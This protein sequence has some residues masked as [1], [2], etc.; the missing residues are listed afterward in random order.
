MEYMQWSRGLFPPLVDRGLRGPDAAL[1]WFVKLASSYHVACSSF[2]KTTSNIFTVCL[3]YLV[4]HHTMT[5]SLMAKQQRKYYSKIRSGQI[6]AVQVYVAECMVAIYLYVFSSSLVSKQNVW[7][8]TR[9]VWICG[10]YLTHISIIFFNDLCSTLCVCNWELEFPDSNLVNEHQ[11]NLMNSFPL[12][13]I[14]VK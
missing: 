13:G 8:W 6:L 14:Q 1:S 7:R 3:L 10:R 5:P 4:M 12:V 9:N 2:H 11:T